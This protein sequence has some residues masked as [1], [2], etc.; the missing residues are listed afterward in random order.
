[1]A[2]VLSG[3]EVAM[4]LLDG[5]LPVPRGTFAVL[6]GLVAAARSSPASS[7][8]KP[9]RGPVMSKTRKAAQW[10]VLAASL[11]AGFEGLRTYVYRDP[12]GIPTYCF[13]ETK[14]PKW[15]KRYTVDECRE[16]LADRLQEFGPPL[17]LQLVQ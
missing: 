10:A 13:G 9:S 16:L 15:G 4:P 17:R 1:L 5:L 14:N 6:S 8:R 7:S 2:G 3:L 11:V 12:V